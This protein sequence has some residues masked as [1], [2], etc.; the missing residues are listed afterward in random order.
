[1]E[2]LIE[3]KTVL[4]DQEDLFILLNN[5]WHFNGNYLRSNPTVHNPKQEYFHRLIMNC[6]ENMVIDH[7]NQNTLDCRKNNLRSTTVSYNTQNSVS[8][9]LTGY[10]GVA[11]R[12]G[13]N[14]Y[15]VQI[16]FNG[17]S[18]YLGVYKTAEEAAVKYDMAAIYLYG[19]FAGLNFPDRRS[20]Y[21]EQLK[22]V[23]KDDIQLSEGH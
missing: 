11:H 1:M 10:K 9:S 23:N 4:F 6:P 5:K 7:I 20:E 3:G 18:I 13:V 17:I 15:Q 19:E 12:R 22:E 16:G 21:L 8:T 2:I 14:K